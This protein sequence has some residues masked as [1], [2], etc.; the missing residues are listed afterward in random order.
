[1]PD[2]RADGSWV[3][4]AIFTKRIPRTVD[5]QIDGPEFAISTAT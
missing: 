4:E 3:A 1:L 2:R 5:F